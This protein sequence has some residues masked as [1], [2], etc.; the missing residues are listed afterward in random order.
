MSEM[1]FN[2]QPSAIRQPNLQPPCVFTHLQELVIRFLKR[3]ASNLQHDIKVVFP[4]PHLPLQDRRRILSYQLGEFI[5][6]YNKVLFFWTRGQTLQK[7]KER[8]RILS[9]LLL[10]ALL[11]RRPITWPESTSTAKRSTV[12]APP[13]SRSTSPLPGWS[14]ALATLLPCAVRLQLCS[15]HFAPS[16]FLFFF[17]SALL[18]CF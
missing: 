16:S 6:C 1:D 4:N 2:C 10:S 15:R 8:P 14:L 17:P 12:S 11:L 3:A 5:R 13:C 9:P 18:F 7:E